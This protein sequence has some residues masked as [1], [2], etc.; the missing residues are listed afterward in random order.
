MFGNDFAI[1]VGKTDRAAGL[2][3]SNSDPAFRAALNAKAVVFDSTKIQKV[4]GFKFRDP[5]ATLE[6]TAKAIAAKL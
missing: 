2:T 5:D 4:L 3:S 6:D 1:A